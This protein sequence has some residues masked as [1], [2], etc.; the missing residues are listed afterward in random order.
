MKAAS[1]Q[2][3]SG[4]D[5]SVVLVAR[6]AEEQ[7]GRALRRLVTHLR[8]LG[9]SFEVLVVDEESSDNTLAVLSLIRPQFQEMEVIPGVPPGRG[10][11]RGAE[12][13]RG[14]QVLLLGVEAV[15]D[16]FQQAVEGGLVIDRIWQL[17]S[18]A[19][20]VTGPAFVL[21]R[22]A[23][24]LGL[25]GPPTIPGIRRRARACRLKVA[26]VGAAPT[27]RRLPGPSAWAGWRPLQWLLA[28]G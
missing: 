28:R 7:V 13:C 25:I 20:V 22:R 26:E 16:L 3:T 24:G 23:R 6:D 17:R 10:L 19:D 21:F 8:A 2:A 1:A 15:P 12:L 5:L 14:R 9:L 27:R 18:E 11:V 4:Y